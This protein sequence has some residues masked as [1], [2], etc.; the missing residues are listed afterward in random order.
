MF[1]NCIVTNHIVFSVL[2]LDILKT[3]VKF[4]N[5][6]PLVTYVN[7]EPLIIIIIIIIGITGLYR[8]TLRCIF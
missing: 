1:G 3:C 5:D 6:V 2:C 4:V 7:V 8:I